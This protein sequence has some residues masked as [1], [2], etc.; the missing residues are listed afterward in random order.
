MTGF[1]PECWDSEF[2][3]SCLQARTLLTELVQSNTT[4]VQV[5]YLFIFVVCWDDWTQELD[6]G[7]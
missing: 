6:H 2:R 5:L 3:C 7:R 1:L 4:Q